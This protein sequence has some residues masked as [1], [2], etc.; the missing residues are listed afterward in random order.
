MLSV[1]RNG[2]LYE[3]ISEDIR[4]SIDNGRL[5]PGAKIPSVNELR[6]DYGVSHITAL[7]VYK[8][9]SAA[10]YITQQK[11]KGYF[12]REHHSKKPLM[13]GVLGCFTRPLRSFCLEDNYFNNINY[14]IQSECCSKK[15][16]LLRS[17]S[18][19][20]LNQYNPSE[21]ALSEIKRAMLSMADAVDGFI[22]D[23]R[24][25]DSI[26]AEVISK[27][28]KPA[29]IVNRHSSLSVDAVGT[30]DIDGM[31]DALEKA[32]RMGYNRFIFCASG[33]KDACMINRRKAFKEFI[34]K[35]KIAASHTGIVDDCS[36]N[37]S[38]ETIDAIKKM[39]SEKSGG[40][41]TLIMAETDSIARNIVSYLDDVGIT[42]LKDFG[43]MGFG[44]FGHALNFKPQISTVDV[45]AAGIG[46]M[47]VNV[48]M[49]R[50]SNE[51]YKEPKY[52]SPETTFF[53][54]ETI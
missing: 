47:A 42:L 39:Y 18:L 27:T 3:K 44:G 34:K 22:L 6:Q 14:G 4:Q 51:Q 33:L 49:D 37:P 23:E 28:G 15:I 19:E 48:L 1:M 46:A 11:G 21:E 36:K 38:D 41:K 26:V 29:L 13:T 12:V 17:H 50:I 43:I 35:N 9:L 25:P 54:G 52:N 16:N 30:D 45:N 8:E 24:I 40:G 53:F 10:N 2:L 7:R 5:I 31:L 32:A 20:V